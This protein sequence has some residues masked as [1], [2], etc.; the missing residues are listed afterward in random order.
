[1]HFFSCFALSAQYRTAGKHNMSWSRGTPG[2]PLRECLT[3]EQAF[4][5]MSHPLFAPCV[6]SLIVQMARSAAWVF[7]QQR[8]LYLA[9]VLRRGRGG[10]LHRM[11]FV[12]CVLFW[13]VT[14]KLGSAQGPWVASPGPGA[15]G[16]PFQPCSD[17]KGWA[18]RDLGNSYC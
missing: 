15:W 12:L 11:F 17:V 10:E 16:T 2:I 8:L 9:A 6:L 5:H 7:L 4:L 3:A 1:M 13:A 18:G 14:G